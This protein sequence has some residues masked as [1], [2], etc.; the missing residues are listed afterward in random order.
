MMD[1]SAVLVTMISSKKTILTD[2]FLKGNHPEKIVFLNGMYDD[3][4]YNEMT[5]EHNE[6]RM[7]NLFQNIINNEYHCKPLTASPLKEADL[8][9]TPFLC[10]RK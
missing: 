1:R 4:F 9:A 5:R 3:L 6:R 2:L 8:S 10:T 7:I